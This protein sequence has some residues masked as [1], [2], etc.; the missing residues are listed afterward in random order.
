MKNCHAGLSPGHPG[1]TAPPVLSSSWVTAGETATRHRAA[2][3]R[4]GQGQMW[5]M[6]TLRVP[7]LTKSQTHLAVPACLQDRVS[8]T[9]KGAGPVFFQPSSKK[10]SLRYKNFTPKTAPW[11]GMP[12]AQW[13]LPAGEFF[14]GKLIYLELKQHLQEQLSINNN[15]SLRTVLHLCYSVISYRAPLSPL[16]LL[17]SWKRRDDQL[18]TALLHN[19]LLFWMCT[20]ALTPTISSWS[21]LDGFLN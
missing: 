18:P 11:H 9:W 19:V 21:S 13:A 14:K 12:V 16:L 10:L 17:L 6:N 8:C 1:G 2:C 5:Q 20:K 15:N 3:P 4:A 7:V